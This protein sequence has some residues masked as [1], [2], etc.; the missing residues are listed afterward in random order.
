MIGSQKSLFLCDFGGSRLNGSK[1]LAFPSARYRRTALPIEQRE[2]YSPN[3]E[4]DIF[5]LGVVIYE[6]ETGQQLWKELSHP[7]ILYNITH[8]HLPAFDGIHP[9]LGNVIR[10]CWTGSYADAEGLLNELEKMELSGKTC[11]TT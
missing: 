3:K 8:E 10:A 2:D 4:D 5:A 6:I 11:Q 1:C 9:S 7:E